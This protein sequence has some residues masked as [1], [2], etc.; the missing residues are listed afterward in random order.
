MRRVK[1]ELA[2]EW[3]PEI[4]IYYKNFTK[5]SCSSTKKKQCTDFCYEGWR[6][7]VKKKEIHVAF[8]NNTKQFVTDEFERK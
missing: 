3:S 4:E 1:A 8:L 7:V 2:E 6:A 5:G